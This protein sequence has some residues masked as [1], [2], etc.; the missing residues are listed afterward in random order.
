M[1]EVVFFLAEETFRAPIKFFLQSS[2]YLASAVCRSNEHR[3]SLRRTLTCSAQA[4]SLSS[5]TLR[6][7]SLNV[8]NSLPRSDVWHSYDSRQRFGFFGS[9]SIEQVSPQKK[10]CQNI[11]H[12]VM[13]FVTLV[14]DRG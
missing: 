13:A 6:T 2:W 8:D 7:A 9:A 10:Q 12:F 3:V 1:T 14:Y 5:Q 4:S 11:M